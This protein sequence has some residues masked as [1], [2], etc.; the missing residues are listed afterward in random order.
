MT[1]Y[2]LEAIILY[3]RLAL[4]AGK[5]VSHITDKVITT[6]NALENL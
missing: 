1:S 5:I 4:F 2:E 3:F 6:H